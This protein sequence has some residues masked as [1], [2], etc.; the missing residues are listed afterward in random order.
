MSANNSYQRT[1][2][3][4]ALLTGVRISHS[5]QQRLVHRH[6]F[7]PVVVDEVVETVSLDGGKVRLRTP[8]GPE[9]IW[10]DYQAGASQLC[11]EQK[12]SDLTQIGFY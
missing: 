8:L 3:D 11:S 4:L 5:T 12:Y 2:E 6:E 7:E 10:K 1:A 9:S